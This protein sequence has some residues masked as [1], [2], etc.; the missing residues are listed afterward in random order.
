M[1]L[2]SFSISDGFCNG[3]EGH[4]GLFSYFGEL[5]FSLVADESREGAKSDGTGWKLAGRA[6]CC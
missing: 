6:I 5:L 2:R 3:D 1:L 4:V